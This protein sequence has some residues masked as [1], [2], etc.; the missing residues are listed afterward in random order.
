M[1][2]TLPRLID[3]PEHWRARAE[4]ARVLAEQIDDPGAKQT[5]LRIAESYERLAE[6][7]A[8]RLKENKQNKYQ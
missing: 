3:N 2:A 5:M 4:E 7:A 1:G 8:E 6:R